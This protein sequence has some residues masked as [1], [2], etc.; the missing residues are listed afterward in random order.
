MTTN[1][2]VYFASRKMSP[3][4]NQTHEEEPDSPPH[5]EEITWSLQKKNSFFKKKKKPVFSFCK[6]ENS[7]DFNEFK[8]VTIPNQK[9]KQEPQLQTQQQQLNNQNCQNQTKRENSNMYQQF[10]LQF[11]P[12]TTFDSKG[13]IKK[14]AVVTN[15]PN[16]NHGGVQ[17]N[18]KGKSNA[19]CKIYLKN[20]ALMTNDSRN[21]YTLVNE[22][23]VSSTTNTT[24]KNSV[25]AIKNVLN[26]VL[27]DDQKQKKDE[28][29]VTTNEKKNTFILENISSNLLVENKTTQQTQENQENFLK[30]ITN[31]IDQSQIFKEPKSRRK[32]SIKTEDSFDDYS[33]MNLTLTENLTENLNTNPARTPEEEDPLI[34]SLI[35]SFETLTS[36]DL[37][38]EID[39]DTMTRYSFE[40]GSFENLLDQK[41]IQGS[42][43]SDYQNRPGNGLPS[44]LSLFDTYE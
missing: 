32:S 26:D 43:L 35:E 38:T 17:K 11:Q 4:Q 8:S 21:T 16:Q 31:Q 28:P 9:L 41:N 20:P 19:S 42:I 24:S 34:H 3:T 2:S 14:E 10:P 12:S 6:M 44:P 23:K 15:S 27:Q 33:E 25:K 5:E 1:Q 36:N 40:S 18:V 39:E 22:F 30:N 13:E 29:N 37:F 7:T